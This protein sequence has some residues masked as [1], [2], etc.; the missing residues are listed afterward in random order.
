VCEECVVHWMD[1]LTKKKN[2]EAPHCV[3]S[4]CNVSKR[5]KSLPTYTR[6]YIFT[7]THVCAQE[8]WDDGVTEGIHDTHG[9]KAKQ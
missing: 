1:E 3:N 4:V 9:K 7:L 6:M 2:E 8:E 5:Q